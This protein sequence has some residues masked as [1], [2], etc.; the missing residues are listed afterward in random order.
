MQVPP[1]N[2]ST[3]IKVQPIKKFLSQ[4]V[5]TQ[6]TLNNYLVKLA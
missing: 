2:L 1:M 4:P 3:K 5:S 6:L